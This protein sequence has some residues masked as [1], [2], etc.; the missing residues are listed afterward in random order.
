M[1]TLVY[2]VLG[3]LVFMGA[4]ATLNLVRLFAATYLRHRRMVR[5]ERSVRA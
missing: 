5:F 1:T 3:L 4:G 2:F